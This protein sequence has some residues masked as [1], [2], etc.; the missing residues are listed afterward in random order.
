MKFHNS[1]Q[2]SLDAPTSDFNEETIIS[3]LLFTCT[4]QIRKDK[5]KAYS[6]LVFLIFTCCIYRYASVEI[7]PKY[8]QIW[9]WYK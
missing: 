6:L 2:S 4:L 7:K 8:F 5:M 3:V 1:A 9:L